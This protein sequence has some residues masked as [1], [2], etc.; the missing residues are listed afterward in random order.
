MDL[1][2]RSLSVAR[3]Q[4]KAVGIATTVAA[5][6]VIAR[7]T[8]R[9]LPGSLPSAFDYC[10]ACSSDGGADIVDNILM[11]VPLG[12]GLRLAGVP[13]WTAWLVAF[14]LSASIETAQFWVVTGRDSSLPD[15]LSNTLGGVIGVAIADARRW[16]LDPRGARGFHLVVGATGVLLALSGFVAWTVRPDIPPTIEWVQVAPQLGQFATF[17]GAVREPTINAEPV[18]DGRLD[19]AGSAALRSTLM[20]GTASIGATIVRHAP[21]DRRLAPV[22]S[23]FDRAHTEIFVLGCRGETLAFRVRTHAADLLLYPPLLTAPGLAGCRASDS[24]RVTAQP[25]ASGEARFTVGTAVHLARL[26]VWSGW[27]LLIP[28][29]GLWAQLTGWL[30]AL[31]T[32]ALFGP[33]AYW[34]GRARRETGDWRP[35][36]V[37]PVAVGAAL[38]IIPWSAGSRPAPPAVWLTAV[39]AIAVGWALAQW[40]RTWD[41]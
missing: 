3:A 32:G 10:L 22:L 39:V 29:A 16:L 38:A 41:L 6:I 35:L 4:Q 36:A 14:L 8:L 27:Q 12:L 33:L 26:G 19:S 1:L 13:R 30:A 9:S 21:V 18:R 15:L 24:A 40:T 11:F 25:S 31:W 28:D 17:D 37:L 5:L 7:L 20:R 23:V 34:S 2:S